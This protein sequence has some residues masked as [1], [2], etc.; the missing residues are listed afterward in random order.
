[1][2]HNVQTQTVDHMFSS[3][4]CFS[5]QLPVA[6]LVSA[7]N[8]TTLACISAHFASQC[9]SVIAVMIAQYEHMYFKSMLSF[10]AKRKPGC[11]EVIH[12]SKGSTSDFISYTVLQ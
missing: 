8:P 3:Y 9:L 1:M 11:G 12:I 5:S 10:L 2:E 6:Y 4:W 7:V